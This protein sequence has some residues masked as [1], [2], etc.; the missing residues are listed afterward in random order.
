MN[1][2]YIENRGGVGRAGGQSWSGRGGVGHIGAKLVARGQSF[3]LG[4]KV[5]SLEAKFFGNSV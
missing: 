1:I 5:F 3:F 2:F 4:S